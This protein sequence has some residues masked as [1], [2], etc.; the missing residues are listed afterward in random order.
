[1]Y[2]DNKPDFQMNCYC[3]FVYAMFAGEQW[4]SDGCI[5][6]LYRFRAS[7]VIVHCSA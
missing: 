5:L 2:F 3:E 1:M 6:N 7:F 4:K